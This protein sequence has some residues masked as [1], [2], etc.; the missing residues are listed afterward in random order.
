MESTQFA[1]GLNES[2]QINTIARWDIYYRL[3]DLAI[4]CT[5][6]TGQP[7]QVNIQSTKDAIQL[8]SVV[9]RITACRQDQIAW[10]NICWRT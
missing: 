6:Q 7:L 3:Q 8:W 9:K 1:L 5:C 2:I 4:P 10:L